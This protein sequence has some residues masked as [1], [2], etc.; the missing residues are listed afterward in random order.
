VRVGD[1][2]D[3]L[4][5]PLAF[6]AGDE[7]A[8]ERRLAGA[9]ERI[10]ERRAEQR[11]GVR[12]AEQIGPRLVR[13]DEDAFLNV[14]DCVDGARHERLELLLVL[15]RREQ[16]F[17]ERLLEPE[18]AQLALGD[19]AQAVGLAERDEILGARQQRLGDVGLL[20]GLADDD[21]RHGARDV[22]LDLGDL[23]DRD[24]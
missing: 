11:L 6:S 3:R 8:F 10:H 14:G 2:L 15:I 16:R 7:R 24:G 5:F 13:V 12:V 17:V 19:A 9:V 22:L 23:A 4:A 20:G 18:R 21:E 1:D